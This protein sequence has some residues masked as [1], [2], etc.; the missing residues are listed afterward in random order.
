MLERV[1]REQMTADEIQ[2]AYGKYGG[3]YMTMGGSILEKYRL[4]NCSVK[5]SL[6]LMRETEGLDDKERLSLIHI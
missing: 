3:Q 6:L 1:E 2:N 5:F 4:E